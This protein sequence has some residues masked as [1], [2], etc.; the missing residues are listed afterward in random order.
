MLAGH[1]I[2]RAQFDVH[3][4]G[5]PVVAPYGVLPGAPGA[6]GQGR[7]ADG[8]DGAVEVTS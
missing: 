3:K 5:R 2:R 6:A 7:G 1:N 8:V 4:D